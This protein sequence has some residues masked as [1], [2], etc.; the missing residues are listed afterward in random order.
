MDFIGLASSFVISLIAGFG[1]SFIDSVVYNKS[2]EKRIKDCFRRAVDRWNVAEDIKDCVKAKE[3]EYFSDLENYLKNP[4]KGIHPKLGELLRLWIDELRNDQI[5][6]DFIIE[7][8]ND[9]LNCKLNDAQRVL[10]EEVLSSLDTIRENNQ[11]LLAGQEMLLVGQQ[12][13]ADGMKKLLELKNTVPN[14]NQEG[15]VT[16]YVGENLGSININIPQESSVE[17]IEK[18]L[19]FMS[20]LRHE[21]PSINPEIKRKEEDQIIN[22]IETPADK[23]EPKRVGFVVG[24]PGIGKTALTSVVYNRLRIIRIM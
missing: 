17:D 23:K 8:K 20:P 15:E 5:C 12:T 4:A 19:S 13:L 22:W 6:Y 1:N 11:Q 9:I 18:A 7:N 3:F 2:L 21:L 14:V 24:A 10:K 16:L